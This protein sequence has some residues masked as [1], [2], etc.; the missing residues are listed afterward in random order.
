MCWAN[1]NSM[2][3]SRISA[4]T[5]V[6]VKHVYTTVGQGHPGTDAST[7]EPSGDRSHA[8]A[9]DVHLVEVEEQAGEEGVRAAQRLLNL[10]ALC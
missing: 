9:E 10:C 2:H 6:R 5:S 1:K 8:G 4:M 7:I 3:R